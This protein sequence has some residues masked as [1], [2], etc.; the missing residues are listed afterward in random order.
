VI[1]IKRPERMRSLTALLSILRGLGMTPTSNSP[2]TGV[3]ENFAHKGRDCRV[4]CLPSL[5]GIPD[6]LGYQEK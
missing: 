2:K 6:K 5:S 1:A 4:P 3:E